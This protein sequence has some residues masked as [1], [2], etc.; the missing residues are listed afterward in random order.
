MTA[1]MLDTGSRNDLLPF[2]VVAAY[3]ALNVLDM[4]RFHKG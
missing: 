3:D 4:V 2:G 1:S